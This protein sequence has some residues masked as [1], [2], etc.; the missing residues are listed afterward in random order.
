MYIFILDYMSGKVF[1]SKLKKKYLKDPEEFI[2]KKGFN[3][4]NT[5]YLTT[6]EKKITKI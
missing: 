2:I 3:L 1:K 4:D 5:Y 6:T